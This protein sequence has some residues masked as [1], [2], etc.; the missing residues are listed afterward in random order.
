MREEVGWQGLAGQ[1]GELLRA[2]SR[3]E[4]R[5]PRQN[6]LSRIWSH[7]LPQGQHSNRNS[8]LV[9]PPPGRLFLLR[10]KHFITIQG[11][12]WAGTAS[13]PGPVCASPQACTL[14]WDPDANSSPTNTPFPRGLGRG[15]ETKVRGWRVKSPCLSFSIIHSSD[16]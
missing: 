16:Y 8:E 9:A 13:L 2:G 1:K 11:S 15:W 4:L 10:R 6:P 3:A 12:I 14:Q 7:V 5:K